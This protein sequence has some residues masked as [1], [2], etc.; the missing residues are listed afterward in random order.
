MKKIIMYFKTKHKLIVEI[1][2]LRLTI[3]QV[4]KANHNLYERILKL[5]EQ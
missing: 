3:K 4:T 2:A 1:L 5:E